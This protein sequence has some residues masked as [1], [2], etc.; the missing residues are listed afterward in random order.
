MKNIVI[1]LISYIILCLKLVKASTDESVY[2]FTSVDRCLCITPRFRD[3]I[4]SINI[5][6]E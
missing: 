2:G 5:V 6:I 4:L 1:I 3:F